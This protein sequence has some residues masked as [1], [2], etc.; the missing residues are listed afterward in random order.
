MM[1]HAAECRELGIP[2]L[3]DPS[4]QVLRL[5]GKEIARDMEGAHFLFVNDYEYRFDFQKNRS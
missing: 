5:D 1:K 3:Y 2:Y 4:Q